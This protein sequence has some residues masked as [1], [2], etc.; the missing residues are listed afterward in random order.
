MAGVTPH[1]LASA[2][3]AWDCWKHGHRSYL[4]V[5]VTCL[6]PLPQLQ[7][8]STLILPRTLFL[9]SCPSRNIPPEALLSPLER[10]SSAQPGLKNSGGK[11]LLETLNPAGGIACVSI[12]PRKPSLCTKTSG[13]VSGWAWDELF[14]HCDKRAEPQERR[15]PAL[16]LAPFTLPLEERRAQQS[17]NC[18]ER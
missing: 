14:F 13:S 2:S 15:V 17:W 10:A 16:V 1:R 11:H 6:L 12:L 18:T 4:C 8:L 7:S 9:S 5:L 3:P